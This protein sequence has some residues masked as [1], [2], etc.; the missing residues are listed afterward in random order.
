M[1]VSKL[2]EE[3]ELM[4]R[5]GKSSEAHKL[6]N[7]IGAASGDLKRGEKLRYANLARRIGSG[8][9]A[10][11]ILNPILR[12]RTHYAEPPTVPEEIEYA[13]CLRSEGAPLEALAILKD[14]DAE[15]F[16]EAHLQRATCMI[17]QWKY[18]EAVPHLK[19]YV[20]SFK[21]TTY[22][23]MVGKINLLAAYI[24]EGFWKEANLLLSEMQRDVDPVEHGLLRLN[25]LE[26]AAQVAI[27]EGDSDAALKYLQEGAEHMKVSSHSVY[28]MLIEKWSA[29]V[30]SMQS[31]TIAPELATVRSKAVTMR[32]W[33]TVRDC[34]FYMA[35]QNGDVN[36][37]IH[38]YFGTPFSGFRKK[39]IEAL[40]SID[41][42]PESYAWTTHRGPASRIF[43]LRSAC[44]ID[45]AADLGVGKVL[46]RF[47]IQ[48]S[49]DFYRPKRILSIY[50][51]VFPDQ[52]FTLGS[53][54]RVHQL[55]RRFREWT[56]A[57]RIPLRVEKDH[58]GFRLGFS[59]PFAIAL[60]RDV[61]P[62]GERELTLGKLRA[63]LSVNSFTTREAM[64]V[65]GMSQPSVHRLLAWAVDAGQ[66]VHE[67]NTYHSCYRLTGS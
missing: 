47:L 55:I 65:L 4:I 44:V 52:Y 17:G 35:K 42:I 30:A 2:F 66:A 5:S 64:Q 63:T 18:L 39:I 45:G 23:Q 1:D 14:I 67:G 56:D 59:G 11:K 50:S 49:C 31:G 24:Y 43:D 34:D 16:P 13:A 27:A 21:S 12:P 8:A 32:H 37:L 19:S 57:H 25:L 33:E 38:L 48:M 7:A 60:P 40:G 15:K 20:A 26:L 54:N 3:I 28:E 36:S 58:D 22:A 41:Q 9:L 10:L 61:L 29:I 6:L 53:M 46:H 51:N 62:L